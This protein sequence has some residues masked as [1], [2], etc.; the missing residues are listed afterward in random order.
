[1][2]WR[3]AVLVLVYMFLLYFQLHTHKRMF[4]EAEVREFRYEN[5]RKEAEAGA[6][7]A[8]KDEE[9]EE[10]EAP[11]SIRKAIVVLFATTA[12]VSGL[13][14]VLTAQVDAAGRQL[15]MYL[16]SPL[17]IYPSMYLLS[18]S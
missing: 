11:W 5:D 17:H 4:S 1:M 10:E 7:A 14:E 6:A 12:L 9:E 8:A 3:R 18:R 16:S 15:G 13:S 2:G